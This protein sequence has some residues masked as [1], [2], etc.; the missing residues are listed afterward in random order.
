VLTEPQVTQPGHAG[1]DCVD[2]KENTCPAGTANASAAT[3]LIIDRKAPAM[4]SVTQLPQPVRY[5]D[6]TTPVQLGD[7]VARR[8]WFSLFRKKE[9]RVVYVPGV[10]RKHGEFEHDGLTW[11]GVKTDDGGIYG[12]I[13]LPDT[14]CLEKKLEF[15]GRDASACDA[16]APEREFPES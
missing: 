10:S 1:R 12:S 8:L 16:I 9:G 14:G 3:W 13:V 2:W 5:S 7:R 11:I 4:A 6:G 15:L